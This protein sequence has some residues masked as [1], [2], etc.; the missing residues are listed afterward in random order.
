MCNIFRFLNLITDSTKYNSLYHTAQNLQIPQW[1]INIRHAVAHSKELPS[2][3]L[4]REASQYALKWLYEL[5]WKLE[6]QEMVDCIL[7]E[8]S[9]TVEES[10]YKDYL[11][12]FMLIYDNI[13]LYISEYRFTKNIWIDLLLNLY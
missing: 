8:A 9:D 12:R 3:D 11:Q 7:N 10:N 13:V 2:L 6:N 5:Y 4:L 1:I